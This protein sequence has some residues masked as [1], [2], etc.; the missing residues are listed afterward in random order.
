[1][2]LLVLLQQFARLRTGRIALADLG[3]RDVQG[4]RT[5]RIVS[6]AIAIVAERSRAA[7]AYAQTR[8]ESCHYIAR[9]RTGSDLVLRRAHH[10]LSLL[11]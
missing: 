9:R 1:M 8:R 3:G 4:I 11:D 6:S 2:A 5:A 10:G 7:D